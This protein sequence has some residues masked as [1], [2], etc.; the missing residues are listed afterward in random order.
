MRGKSLANRLIEDVVFD[1]TDNTVYNNIKGKKFVIVD[2]TVSTG[3]TTNSLARYLENAGGKV[4][5]TI[6][7]F[8]GQ[9]HYNDL[10]ITKETLKEIERRIG[11]E[12]AERFIKEHEYADRLEQLTER[13]AQQ[14]LRIRRDDQ[15]GRQG[16]A[17]RDVQESREGTRGVLSETSGKI[18]E[19]S[20]QE[21]ADLTDKSAFSMPETDLEADS[22]NLEYSK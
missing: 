17:R 18:K 21:K 9:D 15:R 16:D 13:Q 19:N 8:K 2:D 14:L 22:H 3:T 7:L 6:S 5:G 11:R 1:T 12:N 10:A 4:F 20:T